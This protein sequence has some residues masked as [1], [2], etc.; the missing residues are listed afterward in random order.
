MPRAT[1]EYNLSIIN[2]NLAK[3]WHPTKNGSLTPRDVAPN[4][5]KRVW[6]ICEKGHEWVALVLNRNRGTGCPYCAPQKIIDTWAERRLKKLRRRRDAPAKAMM[7][8]VGEKALGNILVEMP[9][10]M[11]ERLS[12]GNGL[13][14]PI[15]LSEALVNYRKKHGLTQFQMAEKIGIGRSRLQVIEK[16]LADNLSLQTYRRIIST[17]S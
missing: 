13:R 7:R 17:I 16:G 1:Q 3:Q 9:P 5:N 15:D 6:W 8:K 14:L 11:W 12:M 10:E 4:S 2:P